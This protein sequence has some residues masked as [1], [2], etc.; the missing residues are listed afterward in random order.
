MEHV[1]VVA[2]LNLKRA[3][4]YNVKLLSVMRIKLY[5]CI[6][7]LCKIGELNKEGLCELLLELGSEVVVFNAVLLK[8]L[9][10][11][12]LSCDSEGGAIAPVVPSLNSKRSQGSPL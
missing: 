6:L 4:N 8:D 7:L 11:L 10:T 3:L 12:S 2:D 9:K 5:G 1:N